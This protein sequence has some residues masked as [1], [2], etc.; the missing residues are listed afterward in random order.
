MTDK[1]RFD[2][3]IN[4]PLVHP[5]PDHVHINGP[6]IGEQRADAGKPDDAYLEPRAEKNTLSDLAREHEFFTT[7]L[8]ATVGRFDRDPVV[9]AMKY[10]NWGGTHRVIAADMPYNLFEGIPQGYIA[11]TPVPVDWNRR[12]YIIRREFWQEIMPV[13]LGIVIVD[14]KRKFYARCGIYELC[15]IDPTTT[16]IRNNHPPETV[17]NVFSV[18]S[19]GGQFYI[20]AGSRT[21]LPSLQRQDTSPEVLREAQATFLLRG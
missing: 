19:T 7:A 14:H 16:R 21:K 10:L 5:E 9:E 17:I 8:V 1:P 11:G 13:I 15:M 12:L 2:L 18:D 6:P 4:E 3:H 20:G